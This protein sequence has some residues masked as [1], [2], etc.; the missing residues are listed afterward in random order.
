MTRRLILFILFST[1]YLKSFAVADT[2]HVLRFNIVNGFPSNN[3]YSLVQD[4]TGYL[5]FCTDNGVVKYNGYSFK[6]FNT[7]NGLPS[8]D[9]W[10]LSVDS[11]NRIWLCSHAY[12]I[13][14]IKN[15]KYTSIISSN[16]I[17]YPDHLEVYGDSV[18]FLVHDKYIKVITA[19]D[20]VVNTKIIK[21]INMF[22]FGPLIGK[23]SNIFGIKFS[24]LYDGK[25]TDSIIRYKFRCSLPGQVISGDYMPGNF[26][27]FS[28]FVCRIG[29]RGKRLQFIDLNNCEIKL[30]DLSDLGGSETENFYTAAYNRDSAQILTNKG[31]YLFDSN[32][33]LKRKVNFDTTLKTTSKY[34]GYAQMILKIPGIQQP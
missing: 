30:F 5:W 21:D 15:D 28:H 31:F 16:R 2:N 26:F 32:A 8:N 20:T 17:I 19:T 22:S 25:V 18:K 4:N 14:Y 27:I 23:R 1:F 29:L 3:V 13:G 10:E 6:I 9:V 12:Q 24:Q 33:V 11:S 7:S 34:H